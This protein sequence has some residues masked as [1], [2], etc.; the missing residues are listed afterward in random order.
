[1]MLGTGLMM[2]PSPPPATILMQVAIVDMHEVCMT[3][4]AYGRGAQV[5]TYI[6]GH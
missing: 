4:T 1:M 2:L 5:N 6:D 3:E